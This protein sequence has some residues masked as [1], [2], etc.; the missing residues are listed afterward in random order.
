MSLLSCTIPATSVPKVHIQNSAA[1]CKKFMKNYEDVSD[2]KLTLSKEDRP[3]DYVHQH[4]VLSLSEGV[5][6]ARVV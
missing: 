5:S 2:T 4:T 6:L 1:H 3:C